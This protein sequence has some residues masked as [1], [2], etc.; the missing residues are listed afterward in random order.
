MLMGEEW[1][2]GKNFIQTHAKEV[3]NLDQNL[4]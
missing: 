2:R 3:M 4:A 1:S